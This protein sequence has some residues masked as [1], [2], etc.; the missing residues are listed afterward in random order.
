[1]VEKGFAQFQPYSLNT[2]NINSKRRN[3]LYHRKLSMPQAFSQSFLL[4]E[5]CC[6]NRGASHPMWSKR[7][8][9]YQSSY[10]QSIT[11]TYT[12]TYVFGWPLTSHV[13][14]HLL[15]NLILFCLTGYPS[16]FD[17]VVNFTANDS[18][19]PRTT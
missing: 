2:S 18:T 19:S 9:G 3:R 12:C 4:L 1:M 8:S 7:A 5:R 16:K 6:D 13:L 11:Y 15:I 14:F 10:S 17:G